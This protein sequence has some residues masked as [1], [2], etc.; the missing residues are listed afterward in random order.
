MLLI[1]KLTYQKTC[2]SYLEVG[3]KSFFEVLLSKISLGMNTGMFFSKLMRIIN[4][5]KLRSLFALVEKNCGKLC[6]YCES[7]F[8]KAIKI[9]FLIISPF[10]GFHCE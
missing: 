10:C 9:S 8:I 4:P 1:N 5:W 7:T 3:K 6:P 2:A